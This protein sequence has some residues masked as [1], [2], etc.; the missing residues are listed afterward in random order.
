MS[1]LRIVF[2]CSVL[3]LGCGAP[4][5]R[6]GRE[7]A[8]KSPAPPQADPVL[9]ELGEPTFL[10]HC[11]SC[12]GLDARGNGPVA[13]ALRTPPAD[14]R[15]IAER[16]GGVF[17]DAETRSPMIGRWPHRERE[18]APLARQEGPSPFGEGEGVRAELQPSRRHQDVPRPSGARAQEEE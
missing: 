12:H 15:R 5:L 1:S 3:I 13:H 4:Q 7:V 17:P 11:T 9:A 18:L 16:H 8:P 10:R 2:A 6:E 14:L